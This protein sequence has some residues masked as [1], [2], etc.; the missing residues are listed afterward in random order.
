MNE[1]GQPLYESVA[2][3]F[4]MAVRRV[5][6][7]RPIIEDN[8]RRKTL[9]QDELA[10][11]AGIGRSAVTKHLGK[12]NEANP[13]LKTICAIANALG[14]PPALLLLRDDDW[15]VLASAAAYHASIGNNPSFQEFAED[16]CNLKDHSPTR[17]VEHGRALAL[18]VG[19]LQKLPPGTDALT[20]TNVD[21]QA[22]RIGATCATPPLQQLHASRPDHVP[23][24]L[25]I[26]AALGATFRD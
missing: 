19:Y 10:R 12:T 8:G 20:R 2:N 7:A 17:S 21:A 24:L 15:K 26:C 6:N 3:A 23:L 13:T 1:P 14:V 5:A 4:A 11:R 16:L 25:T 18:H 9:S 22:Y